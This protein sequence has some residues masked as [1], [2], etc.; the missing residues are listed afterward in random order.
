[1]ARIIS[2]SNRKGG[3]GKTTTAVNVSAGLAH[4]GHSVLLIDADP[5][6]HSTLSL[7]IRQKQVTYDLYSFLADPSGLERSAVATYLDALRV[8]PGSS[9]LA[10]FEKRYAHKPES[11]LWLRERLAKVSDLYDFVI[12]DTPPTLGLLTVSALIAATELLV[13]MQTHFL[14]MEGLAEMVRVVRQ[15]NNTQ[16]P[17]LKL[18]GIIPTFYRATTRLSSIILGQIRSSLGDTILLHPV[19]TNVALAEAPSYGRT[20]FQ[21]DPRSH[22]AEDYQYIVGQIE[23]MV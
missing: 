2:V 14:A 21:Y 22:G 4:R 7:G 18:R 11:R 13:P 3:S 12:F 5:Q 1:M 17:Q 15:L 23:E 10:E 6:A 20:I 8:L 16:N 19:R 9:R